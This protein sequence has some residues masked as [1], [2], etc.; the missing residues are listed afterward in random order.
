ME[1]YPIN[2]D[3]ILIMFAASSRPVDVVFR[4]WYGKYS[5][6]E[7]SAADSPVVPHTQEQEGHSR[8]Q[9]LLASE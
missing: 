5:H 7:V 1:Y 9:N 8:H 6:H 4:R 2:L 3:P